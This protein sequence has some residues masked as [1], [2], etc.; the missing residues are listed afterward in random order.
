M[1]QTLII[2]Q[3]Q[4]WVIWLFKALNGESKSTSMKD[5]L[6]WDIETCRNWVE[7]QMTPDMNWS[8]IEIDHVKLL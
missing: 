2:K 8:N 6:G 5:L 1:K 4:T 7:Y 3:N